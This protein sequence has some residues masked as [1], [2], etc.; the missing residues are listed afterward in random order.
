MRQRQPRPGVIVPLTAILLIFLLGMVAFVVDIGWITVAQSD[1]QNAADAA[2]L[3]GAN[4][5]MDGFVT[6]HLPQQSTARKAAALA[7]AQTRARTTAKQYAQ[8]NAAGGVSSLMLLDADIEFGFTDASNNYTPSPSYTGYPN[9]IKVTIRRDRKAN[10]PLGLF[11]GQL[12][13]VSS[14]S[15]AATAAA[16]I[17][18]GTIENLK[19]TNTNAGM[20][21]MTYDVN[22]WNDFLKTGKGPD[23]TSLTDD[24]GDP[25]ILVYPSN[26]ST[27]NFGQLSLNDSHVGQNTEASWVSNGMTASDIQAL[28]DHNLIP[29]SSHPDQW[30]WQGETGFKASLVMDINRGAGKIFLMPLFKPKNAAAKTY[31]AGESKG[32]NYQYNIVQIVGI[33]IVPTTDVNG[34]ILVQPA[35]VIE[36]NAIFVP[37]SIAPAGTTTTL[38]TTF[39]APRLS[40]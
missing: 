11:F 19:I 4:A 30:D 35:A 32:A 39:T 7:A 40:Q 37:N 9:T 26:K 33:R 31:Q 6:Y 16:T 10:A 17:Y 34:K 1:L 21:P 20:L 23:G 27:G 12:M 36:P 14:T 15:L 25:D 38:V 5:L 13:G 3:A 18:T 29:L 2:A 24:A 8:G 22:H 28:R